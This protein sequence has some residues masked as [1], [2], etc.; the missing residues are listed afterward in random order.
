[1]VLHPL[2][3]ISETGGR[4]GYGSDLLSENEGKDVSCQGVIHV[5]S[6]SEEDRKGSFVNEWCIAAFGYCACSL[7]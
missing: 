5:E 2:R 3:N 7:V 4:I 6:S 1:M